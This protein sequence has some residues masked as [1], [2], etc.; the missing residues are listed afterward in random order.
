MP[1]FQG[2]AFFEI[3]LGSFSEVRERFFNGITLAGGAYLRTFSDVHTI[4]IILAGFPLDHC[5]KRSHGHDLSSRPVELAVISFR[6][7]YHM[8]SNC[9]QGSRANIASSD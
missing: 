9:W 5:G 1:S 4:L 7:S 2:R 6:Q 3:Q 8:T